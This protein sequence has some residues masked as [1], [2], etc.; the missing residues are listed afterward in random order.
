MV[1]DQSLFA[2]IAQ[3]DFQLVGNIVRAGFLQAKDI[4][5]LTVV[6]VRP[7]LQPS[8]VCSSVAVIRSCSPCLRTE[9]S[10]MFATPRSVPIFF[11]LTSL[12]L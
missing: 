3:H 5:E 11:R 6:S 4:G 1:F 7:L 12:P 8:E 2:I 9:P 10:R